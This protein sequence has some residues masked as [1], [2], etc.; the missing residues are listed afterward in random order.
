MAL[1]CVEYM[2]VARKNL[3]FHHFEAQGISGAKRK[4]TE[5][6]SELGWIPYWKTQWKRMGDLKIG[7]KHWRMFVYKGGKARATVRVYRKRGKK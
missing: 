7:I 2:D 5:Y 1:Y 3:K 6:L 4:A